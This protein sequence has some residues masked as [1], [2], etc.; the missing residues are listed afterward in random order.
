MSGFQLAKCD[1]SKK[2]HMMEEITDGTDLER[3]LGA[4]KIIVVPNNDFPSDLP[5]LEDITQDENE[6]PF[7]PATPP[8][9]N[10]NVSPRHPVS[11]LLS[12]TEDTCHVSNT[13]EE[14][15]DHFDFVGK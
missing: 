11:T 3:Q 13:T 5:T 14:L 10:Q 6:T 1:R 2:I 4:S 15:S 9:I 8:R 12:Q 7:I